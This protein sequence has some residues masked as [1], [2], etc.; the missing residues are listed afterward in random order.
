MSQLALIAMWCVLI[1]SD[2]PCRW[3]NWLW[4]Q[5]NVLSSI[6]SHIY[7]ASGLQRRTNHRFSYIIFSESYL[8]ASTSHNFICLSLLGTTIFQLRYE[9][10][11]TIWC[12]RNLIFYCTKACVPISA[13]VALVEIEGI[14]S[15]SDTIAWLATDFIIGLAMCHVSMIV[16]LF[17][18][19][20]LVSR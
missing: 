6:Q 4:L 18:S 12:D 7:N 15:S 17:V 16:R 8:T 2:R 10:W 19:V 20:I 9:N 13:L 14:I 1:Y 11:I 5:C 3:A